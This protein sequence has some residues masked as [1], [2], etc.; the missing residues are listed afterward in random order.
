MQA[1]WL[2]LALGLWFASL[3]TGAL[4][5][6]FKT[7]IWAF[8]DSAHGSI[9]PNAAPYPIPRYSLGFFIFP[10]SG[11]LE[12][13]SLATLTTNYLFQNMALRFNAILELLFVRHKFQ[14]ASLIQNPYLYL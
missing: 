2:D 11:S 13:S 12:P 3:C 5:I 9:L 7:A 4:L 10:L 6:L 1:V 8:E 14:Q